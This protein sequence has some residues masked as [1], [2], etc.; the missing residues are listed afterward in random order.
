MASSW[1]RLNE[2]P[3]SQEANS[4]ARGLIGVKEMGQPC[5][6]RMAS[7]KPCVSAQAWQRPLMS[8]DVGTG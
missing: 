6:R 4:Q 8:K 2:E 3:N 7:L 1:L 5:E